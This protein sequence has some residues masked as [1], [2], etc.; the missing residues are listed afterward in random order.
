MFYLK[1][2][3]LLGLAVLTISTNVN[4]HGV[5]ISDRR[6]N[7]EVVVGE[8]AEEA[9]YK[10]SM[11]TSIKAFDQ[12]YDTQK[13]EIVDMKDHVELKF[14]KK[15]VSLF[16]INFDYGY[17]SNTVNGKWINKPMDQVPGST[18]GTKALKFGVVYI[19]K[20]IKP[21]FIKNVD[22]QLVPKVNPLTLKKGDNLSLQLLY[23]GKPMSQTDVILDVINDVK[24]VVKTDRNGW[25]TIKV[26][27]NALNV[28]GAETEI[29][30]K[31]KTIKGTKTKYFTTVSFTLPS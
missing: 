11:I 9:S 18:I 2:L 28:I 1:K 27:N 22:L 3:T 30:F 8:G 25:V 17:W 20:S 23:Q 14:D 15:K 4:A 10:A 24:K 7:T 31:E 21:K 6:G 16:T 5:W 29:P 26:Q 13:I 12:T 19:E